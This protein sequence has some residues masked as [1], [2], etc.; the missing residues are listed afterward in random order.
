M[1]MGR[2]RNHRHQLGRNQHGCIDIAAAAH[3]DESGDTHIEAP[4]CMDTIKSD[5][6]KKLLTNEPLSGTL[7][8]DQRSMKPICV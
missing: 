3:A 5:H 6:S 4:Y 8:I 7:I 2:A 1:Q